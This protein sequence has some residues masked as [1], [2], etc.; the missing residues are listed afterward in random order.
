MKPARPWE[1]L[2]PSGY[3]AEELDMPFLICER[4]PDGVEISAPWRKYDTA[5][6]ANEMMKCL[7]DAYPLSIF[8]MKREREESED[9]SWKARELGRFLDGTYKGLPWDFEPW[10]AV[11]MGLDHYAHVALDDPSKIA[12]TPNSE[13]GQADRQQRRRPGRYLELIGCPDVQLWAARYA[14]ANE[15]LEVKFAETADE[16]E[17]VYLNGPSSCMSHNASDYESNCHPVRAY[18]AG[19]LSVAYLENPDNPG[20]IT[21]RAVCWREKKIYN[22]IYGDEGRLSLLLQA[23]GFEC[24]FNSFGDATGKDGASFAGARLLKLEHDDT[25]VMPY[26]DGLNC[27]DDNGEF[28]IIKKFGE[29]VATETCGILESS[30]RRCDSCGE[31]IDDE[32]T[33]TINDS[34]WCENCYS[35]NTWSC[36]HCEERFETDDNSILFEDNWWC[37]HCADRHLA[38]CND[39]EEYFRAGDLRRTEDT[40]TD[41]CLNCSEENHD[42]KEEEEEM[43]LSPTSPRVDDPRQA[44]LCLPLRERTAA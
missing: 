22:R 28:F 9:D 15:K 27:V 4:E 33:Y 36:D 21:A 11:L 14:A 10:S 23:M 17:R 18:A 3:P 20:R 43:Q 26:L 40:D 30:R 19:D 13:F 5:Q 2:S 7:R 16:I 8:F 6:E 38:R 12:Y 37:T 44:E 35:E 32:H 42:E 25:Y 41:V 39:C 29:Y 1:A 31:R 34:S 24:V